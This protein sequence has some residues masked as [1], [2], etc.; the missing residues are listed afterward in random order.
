MMKKKGVRKLLSP[1]RTFF[2]WL[3][4]CGSTAHQHKPKESGRRKREKPRDSSEFI[5]ETVEICEFEAKKPQTS[6]RTL[7]SPE[8]SMNK[9]S[10]S[11]HSSNEQVVAP[12]NSHG[13]TIS[14]GDPTFSRSPSIVLPETDT[15]SPVFY[16]HWGNTTG[17]MFH[18]H[19]LAGLTDITSG[20]NTQFGPTGHGHLPAF[21]SLGEEYAYP[22]HHHVGSSVCPSFDVTYSPFPHDSLSMHQEQ[23]EFP[24]PSQTQDSWSHTVWGVNFSSGTSTST[25]DSVI[26]GSHDDWACLDP[27]DEIL[28][29]ELWDYGIDKLPQERYM[30]KWEV[31]DLYD[32]ILYE[33]SMF[34]TA[35]ITQ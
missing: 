15:H 11:N 14:A 35:M 3:V 8:T 17:Y 19:L 10:L 31:T 16:S 28:Y 1:L 21:K 33:G 32:N 30:G 29:F 34:P 6:S 9:D 27:P 20:D 23:Q 22:V 5:E 12:S 18:D 4:C 26:S 13:D 25:S 24:G 7:N 2:V